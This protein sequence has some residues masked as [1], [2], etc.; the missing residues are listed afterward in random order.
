M[1][2]GIIEFRE[3]DNPGATLLSSLNSHLVDGIKGGEVLVK[4]FGSVTIIVWE[5]HRHPDGWSESAWFIG[6]G[7]SALDC[8]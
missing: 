6:P 2:I 1:D 8:S 5:E 7:L 4:E 3:V